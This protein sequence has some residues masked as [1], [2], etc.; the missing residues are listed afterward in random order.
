MA[1]ADGCANAGAPVISSSVTAVGVFRHAVPGGINVV[2]RRGDGHF[3]GIDPHATAAADAPL[4][5][6][7][8]LPMVRLPWSMIQRG[9]NRERIMLMQEAKHPSHALRR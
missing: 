5:P 3:G 2:Y 1:C 9:A 7:G 8:T 4:T 6:T